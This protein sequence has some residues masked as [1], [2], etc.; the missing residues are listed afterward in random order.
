MNVL[1]VERNAVS[2]FSVGATRLPPIDR[3]IGLS[4]K[5][6][7]YHLLPTKQAATDASHVRYEIHNEV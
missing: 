5:E 2:I 6:L 4:M 3:T 7:L 1:R